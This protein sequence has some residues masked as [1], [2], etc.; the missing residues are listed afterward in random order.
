MKTRKSFVTVV[1]L[2]TLFALVALPVVASADVTCTRVSLQKIGADSGFE[3]SP[4]QFKD[5]IGTCWN[6]E[7]RQFYLNPS[8]ANTGLA[9]V[10][11]GAGLGRTFWVRIAGDAAGGSLINIIFIN[12]AD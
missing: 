3:G 10:L 8:I 7:N 4:I 12:Q 6:G 1:S 2:F 11:T 5:E 9:I